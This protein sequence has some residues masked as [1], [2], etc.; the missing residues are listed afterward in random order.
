[1]E[2]ANSVKVLA[3]VEIS[4]LSDKFEQIMLTEGQARKMRDALFLILCP[5][6]KDEKNNQEFVVTTND[7]VTITIPNVK[8]TYTEKDIK[9]DEAAD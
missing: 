7:E 9:D 2:E 5:E 6:A 3:F 4:P 8:D 1:M